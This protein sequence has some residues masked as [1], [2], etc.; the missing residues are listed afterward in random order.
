MKILKL[1]SLLIITLTSNNALADCVPAVCL[2]EAIKTYNSASLQI[3]ALEEQII[4]LKND[5]LDSALL[6]GL[7]AGFIQECPIGWSP[8]L[9]LQGRFLVGAAN[10]GSKNREHA[11]DGAKV[12]QAMKPG[13]FGGNVSSSLTKHSHTYKDRYFSEHRTYIDMGSDEKEYS[14]K[15]TIGSGNSDLDNNAFAY[16]N[17]TTNVSGK[18]DEG[19]NDQSNYPPYY[20]V[21]WCTKD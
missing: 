12:L 2:Q 20:V 9:D 21:N 1:S 8:S 14:N 3:K 18:L 11:N 13:S 19:A 7:T 6:K 10:N 15:K 5:K 16:K 17:V 4:Q